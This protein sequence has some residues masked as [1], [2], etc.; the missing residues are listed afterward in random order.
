MPQL[1]IPF[2]LLLLHELGKEDILQ[3]ASGKVKVLQTLKILYFGDN[4]VEFFLK[5]K[6]GH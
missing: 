4:L 6:R 3:M 1:R 2:I 5:L